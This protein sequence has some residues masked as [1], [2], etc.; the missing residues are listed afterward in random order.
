MTRENYQT[1][2]TLLTPWFDKWGQRTRLKGKRKKILKKVKAIKNVSTTKYKWS[3]KLNYR[4]ITGRQISCLISLV[5]QCQSRYST[6]F[7]EFKCN[8]N[9]VREFTST[10]TIIYPNDK[11]KL[12]DNEYDQR[13]ARETFD[14]I[15]RE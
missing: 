5:E 12:L 15:F 4:S 6:C 7:E 10:L 3:I 9:H 14:H 11:R 2:K 1:T 8:I 13:K